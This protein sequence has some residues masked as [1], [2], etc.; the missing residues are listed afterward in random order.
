MPQRPV[1][2]GQD[3]PEYGQAARRLAK[4]VPTI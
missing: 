1:A 3:F 4:P 2:A